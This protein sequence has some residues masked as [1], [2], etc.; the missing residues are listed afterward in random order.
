MLLNETAAAYGLFPVVFAD[1]ADHLAVATF[2][3]L[4][5]KEPA[6][7]FEKV[8][9]QEFKRTLKQF[10]KELCQLQDRRPVSD[11]LYTLREVC[12]SISQLA[13]WRNDRIH[14]RVHLTDQ[15][16]ILYDWRNRQRLEISLEQIEHHIALAAKVMADLEAHMQ[17]LVEL[18]E[19][20]QE[21]EKLFGTLP[22]LSEPLEN[23]QDI[24]QGE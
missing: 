17:D 2:H 8:F 18:L 13:R 20:D 6:L 5:R 15:G 9:K 24:H 3:L 16:Y 23:R 4:R 22:E 12:K 1:V 19:W 7:A 14:A 11:S 10:Q 21:V